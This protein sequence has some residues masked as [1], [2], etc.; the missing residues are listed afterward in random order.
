[1]RAPAGR[2]RSELNGS[3]FASALSARARSRSRRTSSRG[4]PDAGTTRC[5]FWAVPLRGRRD[6]PT[7]RSAQRRARRAAD[8]PGTRRCGDRSRRPAEEAAARTQT[9]ATGY[10]QPRDPAQRQRPHGRPA[11]PAAHAALAIAGD[12]IGGGVDVREGERLARLQRARRPRRP[13][14]RARLHRCPRALPRVVARRSG[15]SISRRRARTPRSWPPSPQP[16]PG[17]DGWLL[18]AGWRSERWPGGDPAP[19]RDALDAACGDRPVLLWAHDHHTAWLSSAAL[20]R[21]PHRRSAP[22]VER[23]AT[24]RAEGVLRETA[25]WDAAAAV[26]PPGERELDAALARG[27]RDCARARRDGHPRLPARARPRSLAAA[28]TPTGGSRCASGRRCRPSAST[29]SSRS[30]CAAASVTSGCASGPSR[31]SPTARSARARP[32]CSSRSPTAGAA[33]RC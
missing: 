19:H 2:P 15:A 7:A 20:A 17:A 3:T 32:R 21:L 27:L 12:R 13:L 5:A 28:A 11:A 25:A 26:P 1:M 33:R 10:P 4:S 6:R 8:R 31:R 23:D 18:G 29:R 16:R 30:A 9:I 14:R 24:R 22:V